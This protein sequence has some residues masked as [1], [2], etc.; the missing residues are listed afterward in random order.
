MLHG[1]AFLQCACVR[2]RTR[3]SLC[4]RSRALLRASA[5]SPLSTIVNMIW[6]TFP[7]KPSSSASIS[8]HPPPSSRR[9]IALRSDT[10]VHSGFELQFLASQYYTRHWVCRWIAML[11]VCW[12]LPCRSVVDIYSPCCGVLEITKLGRD[13]EN[14]AGLCRR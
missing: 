3:V 14:Y 4:V 11:W 1:S 12:T 2:G 9:R 10:A 7:G 8:E 6:T 13:G 5:C